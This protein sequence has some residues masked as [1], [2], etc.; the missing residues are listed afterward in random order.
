MAI[1]VN[2]AV[3]ILIRFLPDGGWSS[4]NSGSICTMGMPLPMNIDQQETMQSPRGKWASKRSEQRKIYIELRATDEAA[5]SGTFSRVSEE[6]EGTTHEAGTWVLR[7][8]EIRFMIFAYDG[9]GNIALGTVQAFKFAF[10]S[11][12]RI[13]LGDECE[14]H[15][16]HR[17]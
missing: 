10:E 5:R 14:T 11:P 12:D 6:D 13:A 16:F 1:L 4:R 9:P 3:R 8:N 15:V 17:V 2:R 7:S